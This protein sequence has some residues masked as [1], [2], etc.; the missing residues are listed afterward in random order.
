MGAEFLSDAPPTREKTSTEIFEESFPMYL[1]MGMSPAE[2]WEGD[3]KLT[4]YYRKAYRFKQ[5]EANH[6]A[7]LQ[8]LY[9]YDAVSTALHNALRG[10]GKN[11]PPAKDYAKE[12]FAL[13]KQEKTEEERAIEVEREQEKAAA[14][15]ELFVK[16]NQR[17][18]A[19]EP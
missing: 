6:L 16:R 18:R 14:W 17:A 19:I 2:Y 3:A 11:P 13:F 4:Q 1:A 7:W 15:M 10:M 5:E 8:G 12:P 9:V